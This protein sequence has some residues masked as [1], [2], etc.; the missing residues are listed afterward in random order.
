[1]EVY[2]LENKF[3]I[4]YQ[5][6]DWALYVSI[7][8]DLNV[9]LN[10]SLDIISS[11]SNHW[12]EANKEFEK[13]L[14][15]DV[16]LAPLFS[17]MFYIWKDNHQLTTWWRH[18]NKFHATNKRWHFFV[19]YIV[20]NPRGST[21]VFLNAMSNINWFVT[22]TSSISFLHLKVNSTLSS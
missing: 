4:G 8:N 7:Y 22:F 13:K 19:D 20:V 6:G 17:K 12:L 9:A 21:T 5:E 11:W 16:D 15:K 1:M 3:V 14:L 10:V 2:K 18:I